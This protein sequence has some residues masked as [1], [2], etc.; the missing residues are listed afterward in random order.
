MQE[1]PYADKETISALSQAVG[2]LAGG[3]DGW[4]SC[5]DRYQHG[6]QQEC[7]REQ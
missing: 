5:T 3:R 6:N 4:R 7:R 2:A 1:F